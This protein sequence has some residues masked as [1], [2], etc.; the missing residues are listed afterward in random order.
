M[1]LFELPNYKRKD[2]HIMA[3]IL[4]DLK[5]IQE[6]ANCPHSS[7]NNDASMIEILNIPMGQGVDREVGRFEIILIISG[8]ILL[9]KK[10]F[11]TGI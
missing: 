11:L 4:H 2:Q 7:Q 3:G 8:E 10:G 5:D 9:S 6:H 1:K